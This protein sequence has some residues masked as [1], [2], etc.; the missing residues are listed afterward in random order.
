MEEVQNAL[1]VKGYAKK[2]ED[3]YMNWIRRYVRYFLPKHPCETGVGGVREY[4][5]FL[6]I[7]GDIA[8]STQ[9]QCLAALLFLYKTLGIELGQINMVRAKKDKT[10]PT[11]LTVNET[12]SLLTNLDGVYRI[13]GEII[14]GG[15]LRLMECLRLRVKDLDFE[16]LS[17]TLRK[18][19]SNRDRVTCLAE[20]VVPK[21]KLHLAKVKVTIY[22]ARIFSFSF[23]LASLFSSEAL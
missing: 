21:L 7:E 23:S 10:L 2:T 13:M 14:Y 12:M 19:K 18:T 5:T 16:N 22:L 20:T 8:P 4:L 6:A 3:Q 1:R 11:V 9:N 17:I 15:G